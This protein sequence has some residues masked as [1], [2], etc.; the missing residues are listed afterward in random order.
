MFDPHDQAKG[1]HVGQSP[2]RYGWVDESPTATH[3]YVFP[4]VERLM[5][6][7][8][9][10]TIIDVGCGNGWIA[11]QLAGGGHQVVGIDLALDG[12]ELARRAH[13]KVRFEV[14][15]VYDDLTDIVQSVDLVICTEVI[16]HLYSPQRL[17]ENIEA[18]LR[19]GGVL[20]LSTPYHGYLKNLALGLL[21]AWDRHHDIER[22][23][24]HIKFFSERVLRRMLEATGFEGVVFSNAGRLPW[25]WKSMVARA[26]KGL[27][28]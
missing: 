14:A 20:I 8:D 5:P 10:L 9:R 13:P 2:V 16:E 7:G 1:M 12:I 26:K 27:T 21:G 15:S 28:D 4:A 25:L 17:L 11:G 19:P 22:E 3:G 6:E 18:V 23:G 24:G